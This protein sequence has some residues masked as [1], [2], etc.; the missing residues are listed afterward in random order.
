MLPSHEDDKL[1]A[2]L[3]N[4]HTYLSNNRIRMNY[5]ELKKQGFNIGIGAIESGNKKVIQQRMK[6]AGMRWGIKIGQT[7][8][9]L[10]AKNAS[11]RWKD[12]EDL[13]CVL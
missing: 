10:K 7:I 6:Q 9:S 3:P 13:L 12:V 2:S 8:A 1:P 5:K 11:V 4:L